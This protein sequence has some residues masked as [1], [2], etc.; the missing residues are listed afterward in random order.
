M[1]KFRVRLKLQG[2]ELEI[3]GEREDMPAI[4]TAVQQQLASLIRPA[5]GLASGEELQA[6]NT[7]IDGRPADVDCFTYR[8]R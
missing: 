7:V 8:G 1:A 4:S 3:D 2:M 5:A 6:N